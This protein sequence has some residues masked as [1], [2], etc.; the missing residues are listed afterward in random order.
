V[1]W[2]QGRN[3][4][5]LFLVICSIGILSF[6]G[7]S[8]NTVSNE[9][10]EK[11][12]GTA[13]QEFDLAKKELS[14]KPLIALKK[15]ES[16]IQKYPNTSVASDS[17]LLAGDYYFKNKKFSQAINA[18][19]YIIKSKYQDSRR[20]A[21]L[22]QTIRSY[23]E[24]G[25][26][27]AALEVVSLG[28][29]YDSLSVEEK[30]SFL[31]YRLEL[32]KER[33]D[34]TGELET[35]AD[36]YALATNPQ[37]KIG[38]QLRASS[39]AD[40]LVRQSDLGKILSNQKLSFIH[41]NV[42]YRLGSVAFEQSNFPLARTHLSQVVSLNPDS[43]MAE[44]ARDLL[45]Q[46]NARSS[47]NS[48][49]IGVIL[50]LSGKNSDIGKSVLNSIQLGLGL[51]DNSSNIRLSVID[52]EGRFL[53]ARRAVEKLVVDDQVIGIIGSLQSKVAA[54]I[55][56]RSQ[57]LGVPTIVLSQKSD[58]TQ[59]GDYVYRNALTSEMQVQF[60]VRTAIENLK[61]T[62][63]AILYPD[64]PYGNEYANLFWDAVQ[65]LGGQVRAAQPYDPKETDFRIPIQKMVGTYYTADREQ[66]YREK[67][68]EWKKK[69]VRA[70]ARNEVP[71]DLLPPLVD[72][73]AIFIPDSSRALG[74]IAAMLTFQD[75]KDITLLGT[76]LW[77]TPG[78]A[79]RAG[80]FANS[81]VFVDSFLKQ[82]PNFANSDFNK[83]YVQAFGTQP[84][85]F[86]LQ[87]YDTALILKSAL[88]RS[89]SRSDLQANLAEIRSL[90]GA[91]NTINSE[92]GRDFSRPIA[93]LTLYDGK[94]LHLDQAKALGQNK[95]ASSTKKK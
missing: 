40:S 65:K 17:A 51:Y 24:L 90:K 71:R 49:S 88:A 22:Q 70:S 7:C 18:Y 30:I 2:R 20:G 27:E 23:L 57:A 87:A 73:Q 79:Q 95:D 42:H 78:L 54:A 83:K 16:I 66:E 13:Q 89:S 86:D 94:I 58:I 46:L 15:L 21:A 53:D 29:R 14:Q 74:Q 12:H 85:P 91:I 33:Q 69:N 4:K 50:P 64:D 1:L 45:N 59:I 9:P 37:T 32:L 36:I 31:Q 19:E 26:K 72:F 63:F 67:L 35:L 6:F 10:L 5:A 28:L 81:I 3:M 34:V 75:V 62:R 41:A 77:N 80:S 25:N 76:N 52:S 84:S 60:L 82:D 39:L 55:A 93:A 61:L 8:T 43:E 56:S 92:P 68:N 38:A 47:V 11:A 48:R 44:S